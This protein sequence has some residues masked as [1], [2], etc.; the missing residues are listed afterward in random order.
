MINSNENV[1][2]VLQLL[3][4]HNCDA[5]YITG[6]DIYLNEYVALENS[7]RFFLTG[8]TGSTGELLLT[9]DGQIFLFVDGRYHEQAD[10]QVDLQK[11]T[12]IK[13]PLDK[14]P[15]AMLLLKLKELAL[16]KILLDSKRVSLVSYKKI[17]EEKIEVV[18]LDNDELTSLLNIDYTPHLKE[19]YF[20]E[21]DICGS[22]VLEKL[23]T[24]FSEEESVS[25]RSALFVSALDSIAWITNARG[26]HLPNQSV[27]LAYALATA[28]KIYLWVEDFKIFPTHM[29]NCI[30]VKK[31]SKN[32]SEDLAQI[33][34]QKAIKHA[35]I[36]ENTIS[37]YNYKIISSIWNAEGELKTEDDFIIKHQTI[38]NKVETQA[39]ESD[40]ARADR[41]IYNSI[42]WLKKNFTK[43]KISEATFFKQVND[44]FK[45]EGA[46]DNSFK[47]IAAFKDHASIIHFSS[48]DEEK[49]AATGDMI[50]LDCG[51][52]FH[53]G[54]S[55]DT[56]RTFLLGKKSDPKNIQIYTLVLKGLLSAQSAIFPIGTVGSQIDLIARMP[57]LKAGFDYIH[58]TGHGVGIN[59]HEGGIRLGGKSQTI[60][61][62][63]QL[64]SI[65]PGIYIPDF[66]G[67]RLENVVKVM[68]HP[69]F[70]N[71]LCFEPVVFI[72]FDPD[73]IDY[74]MLTFEEQAAL[75]S[76]EEACT[77]RQ[78]SF[79]R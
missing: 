69:H 52:L 63:G 15:F 61:R 38:K 35:I 18:S 77:L 28:E 32:F 73:L 70:E 43:E 68:A 50:L 49:I 33:K 12:V 6:T 54:Y 40:F 25:A 24:I 8:F 31:M 30:E 14:A 13:C 37:Y 27:F 48:P 34:K 78:R 64:C 39:I 65:E 44:N 75:D 21:N 4:K 47:T 23:A 10:Q 72:G 19:V 46:V 58:S 66:G 74:K 42:Q 1:R 56:T 57:I 2:K 22:S 3:E 41:A 51:G 45:K 9:K 29:D 53:S 26:F 55:T 20:L 59:V 76:Y 17:K 36:G 5:A 60:L 62:V 7:H 16:K 67:V 79:L 11:I 71:M